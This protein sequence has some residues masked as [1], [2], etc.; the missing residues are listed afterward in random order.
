[1]D[2]SARC[3][4]LSVHLCI[5]Q[6]WLKQCSFLLNQNPSNSQT[7]LTRLDVFGLQQVLQH[8]IPLRS[9]DSQQSNIKTDNVRHFPSF[10]VCLTTFVSPIMQAQNVSGR[11]WR[12]QVGDKL[13]R[14]LGWEYVLSNG[15][16]THL[17]R[18]TPT[19]KPSCRFLL[20]LSIVENRGFKKMEIQFFFGKKIIAC[21][22]VLAKH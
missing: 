18:P 5:S 4:F 11:R 2:H 9:R 1:M 7:V 20:E 16:A 19:F 10:S 13:S 12:I 22:R 3:P 14:A 6:G 15:N 17:G 21:P 8:Q